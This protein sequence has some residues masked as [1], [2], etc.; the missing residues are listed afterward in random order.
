MLSKLLASDLTVA[1]IDCKR[2]ADKTLCCRHLVELEEM[3]ERAMYHIGMYTHVKG[4]LQ[5]RVPPVVHA[6]LSRGGKTTFLT[7]LFDRLKLVGYAP[8]LASLNNLISVIPGETD[9]Q[10]LVRSIAAQFV[11]GKTKSQLPLTIDE[12]VLWEHIENTRAGKGVILL[13]DDLPLPLDGYAS[14]MLKE[15]WLDKMGRYFVFTTHVPITTEFVL[16]KEACNTLQC[17]DLNKYRDAILVKPL[18][19]SRTLL[20]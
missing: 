18:Q 3:V 9:R 16:P 10:K 8:I 17:I 7:Q 15:Q 19:G 12:D 6:T 20:F 13:L 4:G 2:P 14:Q 1:V 11:D 5:F